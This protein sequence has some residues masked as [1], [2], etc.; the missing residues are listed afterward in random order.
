MRKVV[1]FIMANAMLYM[2]LSVAYSYE[3]KDYSYRGLSGNDRI[4]AIGL[5]LENPDVQTG[6]GF[7]SGTKRL[8]RNS[9]KDSA[10]QGVSSTLADT[11]LIVTIAYK[12]AKDPV[13]RGGHVYYVQNGDSRDAAVDI[14][15]WVEPSETWSIRIESGKHS[16]WVTP[17]TVSGQQFPDEGAW[18]DCFFA[19]CAG[20]FIL[21]LL[22]IKGYAW[23]LLACCGATALACWLTKIFGA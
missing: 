9:S 3:W 22:N 5:A 6:M 10:I 14:I 1:C 18:K 13:Q 7:L 16:V 12:D 19:W 17:Y 2:M 11:V 20:C 8:V 15:D 4:H 21:C 23:C